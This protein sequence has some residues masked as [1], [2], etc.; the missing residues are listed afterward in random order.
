M[1]ML[2]PGGFVMLNK[3]ETKMLVEVVKTFTDCLIERKHADAMAFI[4]L[5]NKINTDRSA[6]YRPVYYPLHVR[7]KRG[8]KK[9]KV[10][11]AKVR[12]SK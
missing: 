12:K 10:A 9:G 7:V 2:T 1:D 4:T 8:R 11:R 6:H 3:E 5:H